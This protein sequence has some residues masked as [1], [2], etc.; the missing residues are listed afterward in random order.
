[1]LT[2]ESKCIRARTTSRRTT[3]GS[4]LRL[5]SAC[6]EH[7]AV[8]MG[9]PMIMAGFSVRTLRM[10]LSRLAGTPKPHGIPSPGSEHVK[11]RASPG[12]RSHPGIGEVALVTRGEITSP[13]QLLWTLHA[14]RGGM[15]LEE[16][17][18]RI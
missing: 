10:A 7:Q 8:H 5:F 3:S 15:A 11:S 18:W 6:H 17:R 12:M 13:T 16:P 1:M 14:S 2:M 9:D 4:L